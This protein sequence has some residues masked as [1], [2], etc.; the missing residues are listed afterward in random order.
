MTDARMEWISKRAYALW[1]EAG[2][3]DGQD[4]EHWVQ[5]V[6]ERDEYERV[7]LADFV[8]KT[9]VAKPLI[10]ISKKAKALAADE[11]PN[12]KAASKALD[13]VSK[14]TVK[15][16]AAKVGNDNKTA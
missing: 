10:E 12:K 9:K 16:Q 11:K 1:E 5:A 8:P 3:P 4:T 15:A 6:R 13:A 2:R 14:A 7:A